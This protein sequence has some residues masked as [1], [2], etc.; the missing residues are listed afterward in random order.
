M[1][2]KR[3]IPS[4]ILVIVLS[5]LAYMHIS[6]R[7]VEPIQSVQHKTAKRTVEGWAWVRDGVAITS[8]LIFLEEG[9]TRIGGR[10]ALVTAENVDWGLAA[11]KL[12]AKGTEIQP[13]ETLEVRGEPVKIIGTTREHWLI[14]DGVPEK[15]TGAPLVGPEGVV[16]II[17][18]HSNLDKRQAIA[19]DATILKE[20]LAEVDE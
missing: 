8:Q 12:E 5:I 2:K 14:V 19:C 3:L 7:E 20:F 13:C 9:T 16:G 17:V 18:G 11:L 15:S 10:D 4:S 6:L 1:K